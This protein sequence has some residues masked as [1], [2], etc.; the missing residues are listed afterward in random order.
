LA[1]FAEKNPYANCNSYIL[2]KYVFGC[3]LT[4]LAKF[5][6][7]DIALCSPLTLFLSIAFVIDS[8]VLGAVLPKR[9]GACVR[10]MP[11]L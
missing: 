7:N 11:F 5:G 3:P 8:S 10:Y 1:Q 9:D 4:G 6:A 2:L